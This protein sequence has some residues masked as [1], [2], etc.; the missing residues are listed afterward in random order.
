MTTP[1]DQNTLLVRALHD[2]SLGM[3]LAVTGGGSGAISALLSVP[4][5][6]RTVLEAVVPYSAAATADWL[7]SPPEKYCSARTARAMAAAAFQRSLD[8][9]ARGDPP[10]PGG[11]TAGVGCTASLASDRPKLGP[12]RAHV[13]VQTAAATATWSLE[14]AKDRRTRAE[15]EQLIAGLILNALAESAELEQRVKLGLFTHEEIDVELTAAPAAWQ[16]L[17][18]GRQPLTAAHNAGFDHAEAAVNGRRAIFP[19][20]FNPL[21]AG[22]QQMAE[23]AGQM[24]QAAVE[25]EISIVNVDKPPLD[26]TEMAL[27]SEQFADNQRLWFSRAATFVEKSRLFPDATF[28]VGTD[29]IVRLAAPRYYGHD[30]AACLAAIAEIAQNGGRFLVF[31]RSGPAGFETLADLDLPPPLATLCQ[32]VSGDTFRLD[33]SSTELR[34][35]AEGG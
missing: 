27:R 30:Q 7:G 28:I 26:Y 12:H 13:A 23:L 35:A 1:L 2:R 18:L 17:L 16:E 15:E 22:H 33:I 10:R 14:L 8:L 19:G 21:H 3:V 25:Y 32:E 4:G 6:S 29:T 34:Q 9:G 11:Q 24:L 31:G 20:A 5:A